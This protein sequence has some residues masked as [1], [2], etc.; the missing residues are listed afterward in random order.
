M[1]AALTAGKQGVPPAHSLVALGAQQHE[2]RQLQAP[3]L[4]RLPLLPRSSSL[5]ILSCI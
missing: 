1:H 5:V 4:P 3:P 2:A